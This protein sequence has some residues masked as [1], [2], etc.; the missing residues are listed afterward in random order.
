MGFSLESSDGTTFEGD[1]LLWPYRGDHAQVALLGAT[2]V[3][4]QTIMLEGDTVI[5]D[6]LFKG[7]E[8]LHVLSALA[9]DSTQGG[10]RNPDAG[11]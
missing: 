10:L 8:I 7:Y 4:T 1:D 9:I 11:E 2:L 6:P 5:C 3:L